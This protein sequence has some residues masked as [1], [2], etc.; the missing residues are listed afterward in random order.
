MNRFVAPGAFYCVFLMAA[1]CRG[2]RSAGVVDKV[3]FCVGGACPKKHTGRQGYSFYLAGEGQRE[4][5]TFTTSYGLLQGIGLRGGLSLATQS[6]RSARR[7][8][9]HT[10]GHARPS[11]IGPRWQTGHRWSR[12]AAV[13]PLA[14]TR[15][16]RLFLVRNRPC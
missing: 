3:P 15:Q 9:A 16:P 10:P 8:P 1:I 4:K 13:P 12:P 5:Y 11:G 7:R 14:P 6:P 2:G